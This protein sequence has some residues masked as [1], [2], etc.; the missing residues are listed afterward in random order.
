MKDS[1]GTKGNQPM[2]AP[3]AA[4]HSREPA[5]GPGH[6]QGYLWQPLF[7]HL[8]F[9]Q[10][11]ARVAEAA[12]SATFYLAEQT[13]SPCSVFLLFVT[14]PLYSSFILGGGGAGCTPK[15]NPCSKQPCQ[16]VYPEL[17][18]QWKTAFYSEF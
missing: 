13:Y 17:L 18:F 7:N 10:E 11:R 4:K 16:Y 2:F 8:L 1:A 15:P 14:N 6:N 9:N 3:E 5:V 12:Q